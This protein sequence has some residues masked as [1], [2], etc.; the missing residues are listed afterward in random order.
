MSEHF[1]VWQER[2]LAHEKA[3]KAAQETIEGLKKEEPLFAELCAI[4]QSAPFHG[5]GP[6]VEDHLTRG[7]MFLFACQE[8]EL[9]ILSVDE[10]QAARHVRGF[11]LRLEETL[12]KEEKF[13]SAYLLSHD[14]GKKD[15]AQADEKGWHYPNH[16]HRGA[17][18]DYAGF[19]EKCLTFAGCSVSEGKFLRELIRLHMQV[20]WEM[21]DNPET[22][23]LEVAKE[24][25]ERQGV[26]VARF[27]ALLPTTFLLDAVVGSCN[28]HVSGFERASLMVR[29]AEREYASF[30]N[31]QEE[32][33]QKLHREQKEAH[34]TRLV[35]AGLGPEE[36]FVRLNTP[37]GKE[38][39]VVVAILDRFIKG[40][41]G[42]EDV[43]YVGQENAEELRAR[44]A[45]LRELK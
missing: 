37:Y 6:H 2:C 32:D 28:I 26:N 42:E 18:Q 24:V 34:R 39:G 8:P 10:W 21:S 38:R 12:K 11:F 9:S 35:A 33:V 16:A 31:R 1:S 17:E 45:R 3:Q 36:W 4:K 19:R 27:L 14:I 30:P 44:S 20:I 25:A 23:I 5:E 41:E 7:L 13:L 29:F 43:R 15:T 22:R 40:V